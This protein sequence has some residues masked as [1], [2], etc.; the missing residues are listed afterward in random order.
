MLGEILRAI[1]V[2]SLVQLMDNI[3]AN[4]SKPSDSAASSHDSAQESDKN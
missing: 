2:I 3:A 4:D 1:F